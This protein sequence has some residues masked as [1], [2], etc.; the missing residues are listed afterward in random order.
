M[1][2]RNIPTGSSGR[3]SPPAEF[4]FDEGHSYFMVH[5]PVHPAALDVA[6]LEVG[7]LADGVTGQVTGHGST[8]SAPTTAS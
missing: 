1:T 2:L 7:K 5:L 8:K 6:D 3:R 4:D